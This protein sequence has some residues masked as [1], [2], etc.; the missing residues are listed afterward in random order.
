MISTTSS[1]ETV[2]AETVHGVAVAVGEVGILILGKSGSGKSSLAAAMLAHWPFG[3]ALL[4]ADDRVL[5]TRAGNKIIARPHPLI[6]GKLEIRGY[7]IAAVPHLEA[8]VIAGV[9]K[10]SDT[11]SQ[12]LPTS[13]ESFTQVL[14]VTLPA[15]TFKD[16]CAPFA[17]LITIWP[18]FRGQLKAV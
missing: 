9:I 5:L 18:Y 14:G 3:K 2:H 12:R 4:V 6:K 10:L 17:R 11:Y 7:G 13:D 1:S 15:L 16:D 8:V